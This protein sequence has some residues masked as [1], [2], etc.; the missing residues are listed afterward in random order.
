MPIHQTKL[1]M[2]NAQPTGIVVAPDADA[3]EDQV[4]ERHLQHAGAGQG[5]EEDADPAEREPL[6]K[7][8]LRDRLGDRLEIVT[9]QDHRRLLQRHG[10]MDV[11]ISHLVSAALVRS[12]VVSWWP[13]TIGLCGNAGI[14]IPHRRQIGRARARVEILERRVV[15]RAR[16]QPGDAAVRD[17]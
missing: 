5:D 13:P 2:S 14:R 15:A 11:G 3:L 17:R 16:L 8:N 12:C 1:M 6:R 10:S 7:R 9:R 4:A